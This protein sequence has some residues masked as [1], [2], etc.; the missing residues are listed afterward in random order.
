VYFFWSC[1]TKLCEVS[2]IFYEELLGL[3][4]YGV[5]FLTKVQ[6]KLG[7][8]NTFLSLEIAIQSIIWHATHVIKNWS[9]GVNRSEF[10]EEWYTKLFIHRFVNTPLM[11][12]DM[13]LLRMIQVHNYF[14]SICC[15]FPQNHEKKV[16]RLLIR[17][18]ESQFYSE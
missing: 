14:I 11:K 15:H 3:V 12:Y 2:V 17:G 9:Y 10:K 1:R 6:I 5:F 7:L 18:T 4:I 16:S 8:L 13:A